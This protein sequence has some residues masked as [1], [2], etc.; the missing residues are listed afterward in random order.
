MGFEVWVS[1]LKAHSFVLRVEGCLG[2]EVTGSGD[3]SPGIDGD[4]HRACLS[5]SDFQR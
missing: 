1:G 4:V 3:D 5:A 2:M